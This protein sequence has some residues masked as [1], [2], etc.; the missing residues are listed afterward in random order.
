[1]CFSTEN[2]QWG[3]FFIKNVEKRRDFGNNAILIWREKRFSLSEKNKPSIAGWRLKPT[4]GVMEIP[5]GGR[6]DESV[7]RE[8]DVLKIKSLRLAL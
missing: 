4:R 2:L 3:T 8:N 5:A 6:S 7:W 1:M